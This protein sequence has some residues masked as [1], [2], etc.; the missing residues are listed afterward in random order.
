MTENQPMH[1]LDG[2]RVAR[3][4]DAL[5]GFMTGERFRYR[6]SSADGLDTARSLRELML[7]KPILLAADSRINVSIDALVEVGLTE[8]LNRP[9]VNTELA[10]VL[11]RCLQL[12][13]ELPM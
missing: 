2:S 12:R 3:L 5:S 13:S 4:N 1:E 11:A 8:L 9:L 7:R 10:S 6:R